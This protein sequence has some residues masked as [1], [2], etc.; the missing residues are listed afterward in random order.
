MFIQ[1][2][3][4]ELFKPITENIHIQYG[5]PTKNVDNHLFKS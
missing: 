3:S 2:N 1:S 4:D 5:S